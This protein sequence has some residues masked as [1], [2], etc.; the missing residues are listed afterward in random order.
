MKE[1]SDFRESL[2]QQK[3]KNQSE[4]IRKFN[5]SKTFLCKNKNDVFII[6]NKKC[7]VMI[8]LNFSQG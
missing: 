6:H 4:R 8:T 7:L 1:I 3:R 2:R 5:K